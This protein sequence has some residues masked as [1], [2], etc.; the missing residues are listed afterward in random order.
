[1]DL[2]IKNTKMA[3]EFNF[4]IENHILS[5]NIVVCSHMLYIKARQKKIKY[6]HEHLIIVVLYQG[7]QQFN[8]HWSFEK[9]ISVFQYKWVNPNKLNRMFEFLIK[10]N[11]FERQSDPESWGKLLEHAINFFDI[12]PKKIKNLIKKCSDRFKKSKVMDKKKMYFLH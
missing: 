4:L 3:P 11:I 6:V 1:M 2:S 9:I 5:E 12:N 8:S 7:I 10:I